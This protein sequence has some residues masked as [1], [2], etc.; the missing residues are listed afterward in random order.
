MA[1][2]RFL[3][4]AATSLSS[5]VLSSVLA[6]I[7]GVPLRK[8]VCGGAPSRNKKSRKLTRSLRLQLKVELRLR[9]RDLAR[10]DLLRFRQ[11]QRDHALLDLCADLASVDRR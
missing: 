2:S 1:R 8:A 3:L 4:R 10:L 9:N 5:P 7:K 6:G 11:S